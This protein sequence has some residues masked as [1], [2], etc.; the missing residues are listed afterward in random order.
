MSCVVGGS[1]SWASV[2]VFSRPGAS[3]NLRSETKSRAYVVSWCRG[4]QKL[5]SHIGHCKVNSQGAWCLLWS[6]VS[7]TKHQQKHKACL[8]GVVRQGAGWKPWNSHIELLK[9][10]FSNNKITRF[11][12]EI[13]TWWMLRLDVAIQLVPFCWVVITW[14]ESQRWN[15]TSN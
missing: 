14:P 13:Q 15:M 8:R 7:K 12:V 2:G 11:F 4:C 3:S 9:E 10:S 1:T 5:P 6:Q